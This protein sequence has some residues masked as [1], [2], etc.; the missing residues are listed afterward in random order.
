MNMD[1]IHVE[2]GPWKVVPSESGIDQ[3]V[4]PVRDGDFHDASRYCPCGP[5]FVAKGDTSVDILYPEPVAVLHNPQNIPIKDRGV[6][7]DR[8]QRG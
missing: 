7:H 4:I 5:N 6:P 2:L 3:H 8:P 1:D